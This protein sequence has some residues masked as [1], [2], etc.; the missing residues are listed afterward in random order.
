MGFNPISIYSCLWSILL[1]FCT[2][3]NHCT[4][5]FDK[6]VTV[7]VLKTIHI[8][9]NIWHNTTFA[10]NTDLTVVVNN[11]PT[12][13][14]ITTTFT[15]RT[16]MARNP[17]AYAYISTT[18]VTPKLILLQ[19]TGSYILSKSTKKVCSHNRI[20]EDCR[21]ASTASSFLRRL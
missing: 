13:L 7:V 21:K 17:S 3:E 5:R 12:N 20:H 9:T 14:D 15:S 18:T 2:A 19:G 4:G 11:A 16:L 10:V 6:Y 8:Q 1:C